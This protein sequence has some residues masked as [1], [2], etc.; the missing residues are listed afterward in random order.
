[1]IRRTKSGRM[2]SVSG[3]DSMTK[4]DDTLDSRIASTQDLAGLHMM[5]EDPIY[6][7]I[8][9]NV[10][11]TPQSQNTRYYRE[12]FDESPSVF[13]NQDPPHYCNVQR[14]QSTPVQSSYLPMNNAPITHC[15]YSKLFGEHYISLI[16]GVPI[17][18]FFP[19]FHIKTK[20]YHFR[21]KNKLFLIHFGAPEPPKPPKI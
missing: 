9:D 1:M 10:F 3:G 16:L 6:S 11:V 15:V 12:Q 21:T 5:E 14:C 17:F 13:P 18:D 20:K 4:A 7:S 2:N 8:P 19:F